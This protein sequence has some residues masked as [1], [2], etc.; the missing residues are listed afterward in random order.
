MSDGEDKLP[1]PWWEDGR[2]TFLYFMRVMC[3]VFFF[4]AYATLT[5]DDSL[6]GLYRESA[7]YPN[8]FNDEYAPGESANASEFIARNY[9]PPFSFSA[10]VICWLLCLVITCLERIRLDRVV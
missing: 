5:R 7:T 9:P 4:A 3:F 2:Y 6:D 1:L 10:C 8:R